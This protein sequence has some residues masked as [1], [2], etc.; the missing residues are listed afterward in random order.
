MKSLT[1]LSNIESNISP[2]NKLALE[3]GR[4]TVTITPIGQTLYMRVNG[5]LVYSPEAANEM[6]TY[7]NCCAELKHFMN[8]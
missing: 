6:N 8:Q 4:A 5:E 2:A 1:E 3:E 7:S